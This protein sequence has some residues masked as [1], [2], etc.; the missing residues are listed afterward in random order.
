MANEKT[1]SLKEKIAEIKERREKISREAKTRVAAAWTIAKTMLPGAAP[2]A[3]KAFAA[4]L[5]QNK[6]GVLKAALKQTAINAHYTK[7]AETFKEVH[8]VELNDL[9]EDPGVLS[10]EKNAVAQEVKGKATSASVAEKTADDRKDAGPQPPTYN[11][12]RGCGGG[13]HTEPK[14]T[15][16]GKAAERP[17]A[18]ERPGDTVDL[19]AGKSAAG[20]AAAEACVPC[21]ECKDGKKCSKHAA[22]EPKAEAKPEA[23][24]ASA[25]KADEIPAQVPPDAA[26]PAAEVAPPAAPPAAEAPAADMVTDQKIEQI[27]DKAEEIA[28]QN[29]E[30][31]EEIKDLGSEKRKEEE[32]EGE[33]PEGLLDLGEEGEA[34]G[35]G[36]GEPLDL[37]TVFNE[38][39]I[40]EKTSAL[41]N[42]DG[43]AAVGD[44]S[45]FAPS[46]AAALEASLDDTGMGSIQDMFSLTG[47]DADPLAVLLAGEIHTAAQV[48]GMEVVPSFT[49]EAARH[50]E[51]GSATGEN[52]DFEDDHADTLWA[53]TIKDAKPEDQG[54]KRTPQDAVPDMKPP[55]EGKAPESQGKAATA[56]EERPKT[57]QRIVPVIASDGDHK[58]V[59]PAEALLNDGFE[60]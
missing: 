6:T 16:A 51:S 53:E 8:K 47:S 25:K 2:E 30:L 32:E 7:V 4:N 46:P 48:A 41:A 33:I 26:P 10:K 37:D 9:L 49:G 28:Q 52:R 38:K 45:Y 50:F 19:S 15:D 27:A 13:T 22:E 14:E 11:D 5:L 31:A 34:E 44:A 39:D 42:E 3:Q 58:P 60:G 18:G 17:G 20:K 36:E 21:P 59:S 35:E 23:K 54:A 57:L 56:A 55:K 12:G 29:K 40:E 24:D 43:T 1:A